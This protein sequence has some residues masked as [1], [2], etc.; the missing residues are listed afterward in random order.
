MK[1]PLYVSWQSR[2]GEV[3][4]TIVALN[5]AFTLQVHP[6]CFSPTDGHP[7]WSYGNDSLAKKWRMILRVG[8]RV[9]SRPQPDHRGCTGPGTQFWEQLVHIRMLHH[10]LCCTLRCLKDWTPEPIIPT[11]ISEETI[12]QA[13]EFVGKTAIAKALPCDWGMTEIGGQNHTHI[14]F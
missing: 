8:S 3:K 11:V 10:V 4:I 12:D 13:R 9:L 1:R 5:F 7:Q 14:L 6:W 2:R